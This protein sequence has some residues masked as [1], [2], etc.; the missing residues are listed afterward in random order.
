MKPE[1]TVAER[2]TRLLLESGRFRLGLLQSQ[3]AVRQKLHSGSLLRGALRGALGNYGGLLLAPGLRALRTA[4][5][6]A[7]SWLIRKQLRRPI[8]I[9]ATLSSLALFGLRYVRKQT[10]RDTHSA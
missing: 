6:V 1:N 2:K 4:A 5:P 10:D 8:L 3:A 9:A 7:A